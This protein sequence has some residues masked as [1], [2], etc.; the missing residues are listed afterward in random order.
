MILSTLSKKILFDWL[1]YEQQITVDLP[2]KFILA[3]APHT[4]NWDF[5]IGNLYAQ[6]TGFRCNF[7]MKKEWFFWP[8]G[9][10]MR[11]IGGIP[12]YRSKTMGVTDMLAR[13]AME[14]DEFRLCITPEGTRSA[15]GEWKKG[16]YYIALKARIPILLFGLDYKRRLISC[17]RTFIPTGDIEK[18]MKEIK[19]YY[20]DFQGKHPDRFVL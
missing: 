3:L 6:A 10:V 7:M 13:K 20:R 15:N 14:M 11:S 19:N 8:L 5:V 18:D 12:V 17:T 4:S 9:Y 16:F 1:G 2:A